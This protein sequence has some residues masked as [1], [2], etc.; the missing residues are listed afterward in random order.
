MEKK[1]ATTID[2]Y[3]PAAHLMVDAHS[4]TKTMNEAVELVQEDRPDFESGYLRLI[5]LGVNA[6][7]N[8]VKR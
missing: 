6:M 5:W 3:I 7:N 4:K 1:A 2:N 8:Q